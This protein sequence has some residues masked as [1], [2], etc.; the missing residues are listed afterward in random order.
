MDGYRILSL[1][2][3]TIQKINE[4]YGE[5]FLKNILSE[6]S[7]P[8]NKDLEKFLHNSA[9]VF[10]NQGVAQTHLVFT[11]YKNN[12][13]LCGYFTLTNKH[14]TIKKN[15]DISNSLKKRM[16]KFATYDSN[17]KTYVISAPLIA[18][19]G[20]NYTNQYNKLI[21]GDE[22]LKIA[23]EMV[24][25]I[26]GIIGGRIV[27]LECEDKP[28][29]TEFYESNGFINFGRRNLDADEKDDL[30]GEYLIQL[31]KYLK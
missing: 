28:K 31:L 11:S 14:F 18:Q 29:L 30:S 10:A 3:Q 26:Q 23:C 21:T 5:D 13:V 7:C 17:L 1:N 4:N 19:L 25:D 6:F 27:Y 20:K 2:K 22:L 16:N 15:F 8:L 12:P 9:L 24:K